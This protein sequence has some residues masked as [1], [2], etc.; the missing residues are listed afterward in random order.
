[1]SVECYYCP[2]SFAGF[3]ALA[4]H[5]SQSRK[6]HRKGK[7]WAAKYLMLN[8]LSPDKRKPIRNNGTPLT[9][10][11]RQAKRD[12]LRQLSGKVVNTVTLCPKCKRRSNNSLPSE[13]VSN[14]SAW[15]AGNILIK[16]CINCEGGV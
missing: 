7:K 1:M 12:T 14:P 11:Q 15:R 16:L 10:E 9:E 2:Q 8:S 3:Q 5:I 6:G 13:Y 4:L